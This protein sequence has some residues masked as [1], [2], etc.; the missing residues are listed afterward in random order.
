MT[1]QFVERAKIADKSASMQEDID[2]KLGRLDVEKGKFKFFVRKASER[3]VE[4]VDDSG[5]LHKD[6]TQRTGIV[7]VVTEGLADQPSE[8]IWDCEI[9]LN[10]SSSSFFNVEN[11][12]IGAGPVAAS[13]RIFI[14]QTEDKGTMILGVILKDIC[15]AGGEEIWEGDIVIEPLRKYDVGATLSFYR[16]DQIMTSDVFTAPEKYLPLKA[17]DK[18]RSREEVLGGG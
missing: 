3:E 12:D 14:R 11:F 4:W 16:A 6:M 18:M 17:G 8:Q 10:P 7:G 1:Y 15:A 5:S 9:T 2:E 13:G